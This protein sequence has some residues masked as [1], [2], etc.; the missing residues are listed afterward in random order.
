[1]NLFQVVSGCEWGNILLWEEGLITLEI[2]KKNRQP[3]HT[4]AITQ[5]E[6]INGELITVGKTLTLYF[7]FRTV[8]FYFIYKSR[9]IICIIN[10]NGWMDTNLVLQNNR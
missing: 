4:K 3:C 9:I 2:C 10:R 1:M 8:L 5:F 7:Q 6:Y